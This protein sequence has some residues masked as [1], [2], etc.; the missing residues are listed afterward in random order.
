MA[1]VIRGVYRK[2]GKWWIDFTVGP[3]GKGVRFREPTEA[4]SKKAAAE[5][6]ARRMTEE[7]RKAGVAPKR[8]HLRHT[9]RRAFTEWKGPGAHECFDQ[10]KLHDWK[11][12]EQFVTWLGDQFPI[13][14]VDAHHIAQ[15]AQHR[16]SKNLVNSTVL[17]ELTV[18]SSL[19]KW[20]IG[21]GY[22]RTNPVRD[23]PK[24]RVRN[25]KRF[26]I[27]RGQAK[28][29]ISAV[30]G[31]TVLETTY[32]LAMYAGLR[33]EEICRVNWEHVDFESATL[34]V[35]PKSESDEAKT[36]D[37][38]AIVPIFPGL[39]EWLLANKQASGP[40]VRRSR[41]T[42]RDKS[43]LVVAQALVSAR[44]RF[45]DA[46]AK[47]EMEGKTRLAY[48]PNF[49]LCRHTLATLM[50]ADGRPLNAV[51]AMLRHSNTKTTEQFYVNAK[52]V[53]MRDQIDDFEL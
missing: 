46:Q 45:N 20:A 8:S 9:V 2:Q 28:E 14:E 19:F 30:R 17:R 26:G 27:P 49:H 34:I 38:V 43:P 4:R 37:S 24:P 15:Y 1:T 47:R 41:T 42:A 52:A 33:R 36:T 18:I 3:R 12:V 5:V 48:L 25:R 35:P 10:H 53:N 21:L 31:H 29:V 7:S 13:D 51:S 50:I 32:L 23:A 6:R 22:A 39:M 44:R 16:L 11:R 40:I